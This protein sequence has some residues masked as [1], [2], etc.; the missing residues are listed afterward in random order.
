MGSKMRRRGPSWLRGF[1]AGLAAGIVMTWTLASVAVSAAGS[2]ALP[3]QAQV[4]AGTTDPSCEPPPG[5][6]GSGGNGQEPGS[7]E[8]PAVEAEVVTLMA[9]TDYATPM[10]IIRADQDGPVVL[11]VGGVH[12]NKPAGVEAGEV[13]AGFRDLER[14]TLIVIPALNRPA[15]EAGQRSVDIDLNRAF[16]TSSGSV[17]SDPRARAVWDVMRDHEVDYLIDMHEDAEPWTS[18]GLGNVLV[19]RRVGDNQAVAE[20]LKEA[21]DQTSSQEWRLGGEPIR[22][23]LTR[24]AQD[25]LGVSAFY[26]STARTNPMALR[27]NQHVTAVM[28][29]LDVLDMVPGDVVPPTGEEPGGGEPGEEPGQEPGDEPGEEPGEEPGQEPGEEPGSGAPENE[30]TVRTILSGTSHAT[31]LY[32][33]DSGVPGP[34]V[35]ISGGVHGSELAGWMAAEEIA[36][37]RVTRGRLVVVPHA[38]QL[39]VEQRLR[40]ARGYSDLNRQ[41][42][43]SSGDSPNGTVARALWEELER[44]EP[45]W[46]FDLHEALSNRNLDSSSVGQTMIVYP[47]SEINAMAETVIDRINEDLSSTLDFRMLRYPVQGSLARAAGQFLGANAAIVETS[48]MYDLDDRIDWHLTLMRY[49]LEELDMGP[50]TETSSLPQAAVRAA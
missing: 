23:G 31:E 30:V 27:V 11:A 33:I 29:L 39:A 22:S 34:T 25:V 20:L 35:W 38:F 5:D 6:G 14:G 24:S 3:A 12:G 46:V 48:R 10:T 49:V 19:Y 41:F 16:P 18:S 50:I 43:T 13:L 26:V 2:P 7:G 37:W 44:Y 47:N 4:Q 42:P 32:V 1:G 17:P 15:V 28:T 8:E 9:G 40:A 21:L 45:D 36:E